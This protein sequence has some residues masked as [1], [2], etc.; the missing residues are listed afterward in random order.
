MSGSSP[1]EKFYFSPSCFPYRHQNPMAHPVEW[2]MDTPHDEWTYDGGMSDELFW[3]L[4]RPSLCTS[5]IPFATSLVVLSLYSVFRF[6]AMARPWASFDV[7]YIYIYIMNPCGCNDQL[8]DAMYL[9][10]TVYLSF[11]HVML[12]CGMFPPYLNSRSRLY[13]PKCCK[14][15]KYFKKKNFT[16][17]ST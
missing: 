15:T 3:D 9:W 14:A 4:S 1:T 2:S 11:S 17:F 8:C 12:W 7:M 6:W 10:F 13:F 16:I 5:H